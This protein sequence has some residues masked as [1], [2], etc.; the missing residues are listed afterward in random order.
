MA[1]AALLTAVV[2][3]RVVRPGNRLFDSALVVCLIAVAIQLVSWPAGMRSAISPNFAVLDGALWFDAARNAS[4]ARPLSVDP[5][6]TRMSLALG[7]TLVLLL[8]S[9]RAIL[10]RGGVRLVARGLAG[11]G[12]VLAVVAILQHATAP[13]L[14][15]W[16]WPTIFGTAFG[17][18]RNRNDFS[19]WLIM[20]IPLTAGYLLARIASQYRDA[21]GRP[22]LESVFEATTVWLSGSICL[23]TAALLS[24]LSRSGLTG[25]A[26]AGASLL[27]LS[28]GRIGK[29]GRASLLAGAAAVMVVS[30]AYANVGALAD[31]VGETLQ[32]GLGGRRTIWR[33]TLPLVRD[34]WV[35]GVGAGGY[36]RAMLVYQQTRGLFYFNHAHDEYLQL[37][38]EGGILLCIPAA[39]AL[40]AGVGHI[41]RRL[42]EDRAPIFWI[43]AGAASGLIAV[44]VQSVWDTGLRMPANAVLFVLLAAVAL[45]E[46]EEP[47]A[48]GPANDG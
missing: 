30:V 14:L 38:A 4:E 27:W 7:I 17:P 36:E 28:R 37:A 12:L 35:T 29:R 23:M 32:S 26:A 40:L 6:A 25:I 46:R 44:A 48:R 11:T 13:T 21:A 47:S 43:R 8:W 19:T 2:R 5:G 16:K 39:V 9:A 41:A 34:F 33:E 42:R 31:R 18:Y 3:P 45:H 1:G 20:A 24:S 10:A 22:G 15:Y